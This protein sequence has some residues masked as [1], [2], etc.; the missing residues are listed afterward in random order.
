MGIGLFAAAARPRPSTAACLI[1]KVP[2]EETVKPILGYLG[3]LFLCLLVIGLRCPRSAPGCRTPWATANNPVRRLRRHE[4]IGDTRRRHET[5]AARHRSRSS[6]PMTL[7]EYDGRDFAPMRRSSASRFE[8]FHF[9][10]RRRGH[11]PPVS[12]RTDR[13]QLPAPSSIPPV[14]PAA[15]PALVAAIR[16]RRLS[17]DRGPHLQSGPARRQ[18][19]GGDELSRHRDRLRHRRLWRSPCA[20]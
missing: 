3:L 15:Y 13:R 4:D 8:I 20:G 17:D 9:Q 5:C 1:G 14:T 2:I 19:R 7:P 6:A 16:Q 18:L 12:R 11:Q 10:H